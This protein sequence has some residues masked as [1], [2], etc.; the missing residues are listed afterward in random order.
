MT[1]FNLIVLAV[2]TL[3]L[4][5]PTMPFSPSNPPLQ[6]RTPTQLYQEEEKGGLSGFM[7][8]FMEEVDSF[9][10]DAT[11]RRMGN[12]AAF[13]GKRKSEFYGKEDTMKKTNKNEADPLED[14]QG[15][16]SA[17]YFQWAP[18][19]DGMMRPVTRMKK[20]NVERPQS[21]WDKNFKS[22]E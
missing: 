9:I 17:G 13:Y 22:D 2:I 3:S 12:G 7:S 18:D 6:C 14:Y 15:P 19:E 20:K 11:N 5:L 4:I 1:K 16:R 8:N 10:D 21:F